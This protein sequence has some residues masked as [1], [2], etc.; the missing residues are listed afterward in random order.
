MAVNNQHSTSD[1]LVNPANLYFLH[2]GE[3]PIVVLV[4][5]PLTQSNFHQWERDMV[6]ALESKNKEHFLFGTL[7]CP[8]P[9]DPM[10]EAWR[11]CNRK[12]LK[13]GNIS[14]IDFRIADLQDQIQNCKQGN[15]SI[16]EY[17]TRLKIMWKELELYR[18]FLLCI[19]S[20]SCS[21]GLTS[22]LKKE[23]E[24]DCVIHFLCGLNDV[25][26]P[27]MLMEPMPSLVKKFS[28]VLQHEREFL[29]LSNSGKGPKGN[30]LCT[31]CEKTNHIVETCFFKHGF[32]VGYRNHGKGG[33]SNFKSS[34]SLAEVDSDITSQTATLEDS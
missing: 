26:A 33:S 29:V 25:Y 16:S 23:R 3:N 8:P 21:C 13:S 28:L 30:N 32:P 5:P 2:P 19:C 17:Y 11:R 9:T 15:S 27:V 1:Y 4:S 20:S 34:A 31:H 12:L 24:D 14:K 18:C 6:M 22:K 7:P 10:H